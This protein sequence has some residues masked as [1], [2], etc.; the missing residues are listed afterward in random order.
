M[1]KHG[2]AHIVIRNTYFMFYD[3][4]G[5]TKEENNI[6]VCHWSTEAPYAYL[7][8]SHEILQLSNLCGARQR[9]A[10]SRDTSGIREA[11]KSL[12]LGVL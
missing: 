5:S 3:S 7:V 10:L 11:L 9:R 8:G 6:A 4:S 1:S 2:R 12:I